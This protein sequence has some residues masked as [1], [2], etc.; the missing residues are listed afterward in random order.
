MDRDYFKQNICNPKTFHNTVSHVFDIISNTVGAT[1]GPGGTHNIFML[2]PGEIKSSKDGL[3]NLTMMKMD[4]SIART[5][6]QMAIEVAQRQ[7]TIV[8]DGTT[9]AVLI[10]AS[11]YKKLRENKEL[12]VKYTPSEI[13]TSMQNIQSGIVHILK[14]NSKKI[15]TRKEAYDLVYTSTD[16]NRELTEVIIDVYANHEN[17]ATANILIDYSAS[18]Q[19]YHSTSKGMTINGRVMNQAFNN[20]DIET[21][22]LKNVTVIVVDG[23]PVINNDIIDYVQKLKLS[24]RSLLIICSGLKNENFVRFIENIGQRQPYILHNMAVVY[25]TANSLQDRGTYHDL[26][27]ACGCAYLPEGIEINSESI[28]NIS[29]GY[30]DNVMIKGRKVTLGGFTYTEELD[31]YI[32]SLEEK[33]KELENLINSPEISK[34][35]VVSSQG[36][37]N[38]IKARIARLKHGTTT[39]YVGGDTSQRKSIN[40]RLAEDGIKALQSAL[41]TGY[42]P[43]C[44][45]TTMN[46]IYNLMIQQY[47]AEGYKESVYTDLFKVILSAYIE[48]YRKLISNRISILSDEE[49]FDLIIFPLAKS[50][51]TIENG[52]WKVNIDPSLKNALVF[53]VVNL[54]GE[55]AS[56]YNIINPAATDILIVEQAIDAAL[57]LAT[58]NTI[59]TDNHNEWDAQV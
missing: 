30:A 38:R 34:D 12:W 3:E 52:K 45:T 6:H 14:E 59:M 15:E 27:K 49:F 39:I 46:I 35:E 9:S 54:A 18:D 51:I 42:Y 8:G 19:T 20:Y 11:V 48:V 41:V 22:K 4:N 26:I 58:A 53:T 10:M 28:E 57:L 50:A 13:Y 29:A 2:G 40:Y 37:I 31:K 33:V 24:G 17:F 1:Y 44:N 5:V 16:R 7:A 47:K 55:E 25:S 43:G 23:A 32:E 36:E 56:P 21:C